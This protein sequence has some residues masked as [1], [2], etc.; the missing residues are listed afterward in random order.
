MLRKRNRSHSGSIENNSSSDSSGH[1]SVSCSNLS[2]GK[3]KS[4]KIKLIK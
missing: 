3:G 2:Q 1:S 4:N